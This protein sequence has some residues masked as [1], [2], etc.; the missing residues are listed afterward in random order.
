MVW[1][2]ILPILLTCGHNLSEKTS[3]F[4]DELISVK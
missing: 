4:S 2:L 1:L 3:H